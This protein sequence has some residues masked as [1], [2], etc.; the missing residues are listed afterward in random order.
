MNRRNFIG[1]VAAISASY[2]IAS[3]GEQDGK[4]STKSAAPTSQEKAAPKKDKKKAP[5]SPPKLDPKMVQRFVGSSHGNMKAVKELVAKGPKLVNAAWDWANGDWETGLGAA[6]HVGS[7]DVANFLLDKGARIDAFA[8]AMLGH[9][10]LIRGIFKV[11]PKT[12][13]VPGPHGIP[14][15]AH[16]IYGGEKADEVFEFILSSGADLDQTSNGGA[17]ALMAAASTGRLEIV[18][19]LVES[20]ASVDHKDK[21]DLTAVDYAKKRK[22]EAVVKYLESL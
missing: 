21:K 10:D 16:A 11:Y 1:S 3:A 18:K 14:L 9:V 6:S 13:A 15:L 22:H 2:S 8:M 17:T 7:R 19:R 12:H 4:S 20:N 5:P